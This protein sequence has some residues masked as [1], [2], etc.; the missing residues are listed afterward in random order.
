MSLGTL[1]LMNSCDNSSEGEDVTETGTVAGVVTDTGGDRVADATI[2]VKGTDLKTTSASDGSFSLEVPVK[3]IMVNFEK[4]GYATVGMTVPASAFGTADAAGARVVELNP[5]LEV[6]D[7]IITGRVLNSRDANSPYE[8]VTVSIGSKTV[9]TGADGIYTFTDLTIQDYTLTLRKTGAM[10]I[11][12]ELSKDDFVD[13][14]IDLGDISLGGKELLRTLTLDDIKQGAPYLYTNEMRGGWG[15]GGGERDW[16]CSFLSAQWKYFGN[17]EGQGEGITLRIRNEAADQ[18]NNPA[19]QK[20]ADTFIYGIKDINE[21][22]KYLTIFARTHQGPAHFDV[23]VID[24]SLDDPEAVQLPETSLKEFSE[25]FT[26]GDYINFNYDLS[27]WVGKRIAIAIGN[28]RWA[29]GDYWTQLCLTHITFAPSYVDGDSFITGTEVSGLEGWHM[30]SEMVSSLMV[31]ENKHFTAYTPDGVQV[32]GRDNWGPM[33]NAWLTQCE[34][35]IA[36][37]WGFQ[38]V[39]K[40]TEALVSEGFTIKTRSDIDAN[41][42]TPESYWYSKFKITS[43]NDNLA[44]R[45][46]NFSSSEPTVLKLT[47]IQ[48]D[49]TVTHVEPTSNTAVSAEAVENGNGCWKF[50]NEDGNLSSPEKY[51]TFNYDLSA[52]TDK[53]VVIC[54]GVYKGDTR[55]GEQKLVFYDITLN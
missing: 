37:Q 28:Y 8:G 52:F 49:G 54:I 3:T 48:T 9:T 7:A 17:I 55:G 51:A 14:K 2:S 41:Y 30:T 6:A 50:I 5:V 10:T 4:A 53:E 1:V 12:R 45:V 40:D 27:N 32:W 13:H 46:R 33:Y 16:S 44:L 22:N 20:M 29:A 18:E 23:K 11:T 25:G 38:Y 21:A 34:N 15:R 26:S 43:D 42:N 31:N 47:A 36:S 35:H 39:N 24:L 19:D